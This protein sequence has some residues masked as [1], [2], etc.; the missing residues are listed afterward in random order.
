MSI[1]SATLT[2]LIDA[3]TTDDACDVIS[4]LLNDPLHTAL[5]DWGYI[6]TADGKGATWPKLRADLSAATY[7][8]PAT[9]V[10]GSF[11]QC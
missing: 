9:Y 4:E 6:P 11:L 10:E 1:Y 2:L 5:I 7:Y 3:Q 8:D